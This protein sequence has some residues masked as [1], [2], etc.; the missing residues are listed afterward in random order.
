MEKDTLASI[1]IHLIFSTSGR[2]TL[3]SEDIQP[4]LWQYIGGIARTNGFRA[5]Q[6]GGTEDHVHVL[7]SLSPTIAVAK[8]AQLIKG[9]S[10]KWFHDTFG[11]RVFFS[12]QAGYGAF[13]VSPSLLDRTI[14]YIRNQK[15]HHRKMDF[16]EEWRRLT[17]MMGQSSLRDSSPENDSIP[18]AEASGYSQSSLRDEKTASFRDNKDE[19]HS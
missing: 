11:K 12:W 16:N 18:G 19:K 14:E 13:S 6:V 9:G 3:I 1:Y 5:L 2:R 8:S 17:E 7:V 4:R 15:E 10:S